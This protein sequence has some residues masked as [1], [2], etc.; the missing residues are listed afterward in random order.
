MVSEIIDQWLT[1][2]LQLD[3]RRKMGIWQRHV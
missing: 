3:D 2:F 1:Q